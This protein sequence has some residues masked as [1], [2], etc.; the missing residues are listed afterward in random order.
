VIEEETVNSVSSDELL[1]RFILYKSHLR[2][3][4]TV[5]PDAFIPHPWPDLSVTRHLQLLEAD[6]WMIGW[7]IARQTAKILHGRA[8]FRAAIV[9]QHKLEVVAAP[10]PN[11]PNHANI[12]NWPH[13]KPAQKAIAQELAASVGHAL[14]SP[15]D[16]G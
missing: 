4:G 8:D 2:Q 11:N 12:A 1:A 16:M 13:D 3:D 15:S 9:Q 7:T 5:K 10:V 6:L 14:K